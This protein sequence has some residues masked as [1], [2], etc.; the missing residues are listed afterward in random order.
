MFAVFHVPLIDVR[1]FVDTPTQRV[2]H[3]VWPMV[4]LP[5]EHHR[6]PFVRG[7]GMAD[8]RLQGGVDEWS[9]EDFFC[10]LAGAL[11]F[12]GSVRAGLGTR[13]GLKRYC[14]FRRLFWDGQFTA[15]GS[16]VGRAEIGFGFRLLPGAAEFSGKEMAVLIDGLLQQPVRVLP[17]SAK[18]QLKPQPLILSNCGAP[19]AS[20]YLQASTKASGEAQAQAAA[21]GWWLTP[22]SPLLLIEGRQDSE[23]D[24]WP[25]PAKALSQIA[26]MPLLAKAGIS[27][28]F[29]RRKITG[30]D[31]SVW[32]LETEKQGFHNRDVLRRLR[33]NVT[34]LNSALS[35]LRVLADMQVK[36]QLAP[37][38]PEAR[39]RLAD[40]LGQYMPFLYK[41]QQQGMAL[42]PFVAAALAMSEALTPAMFAS[43][44]KLVP[45]PGRGLANQ[46]DRAADALPGLQPVPDPG[47]QWDVFIAHAGGDLAAAE[48]LFDAIGNRAKV[49]L[50]QRRLLLGDDW[51]LELARAQRR[52]RMTIVLVGAHTDTAYYL[53]SEIAEAISLARIDGERHRVVPVYLLDAP[54]PSTQAKP[55]GLNLKHGIE[56]DPAMPW[57]TVADRIVGTLAL[58]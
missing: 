47:P 13:E 54:G 30:R 5:E 14:A 1:P 48:A 8:E 39:K 3:P 49:F 23:V 19:L 15:Q 50:D 4:L 53:R 38:T 34:R 6:R 45:M 25:A 29:G 27:V 36:G 18:Q 10:D 52:S 24:A 16:V 7:F 56:R 35:G 9:G 58:I 28:F 31:R 46:M 37:Q 42:P 44:R 33:L 21:N 26:D 41:E 57:T 22:G 51:D 55:Y 2:G 32:Y 20:A 12:E 43:L 11:R 17:A 40:C